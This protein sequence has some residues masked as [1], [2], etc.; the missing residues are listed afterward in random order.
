M[1]VKILK[2]FPYAKNVEGTEDALAPAG[3][4]IDLPDHMEPF[5]KGLAVGGFIAE[6]ADEGAQFA[7]QTTAP[8]ETGNAG[9]APENA[10]ANGQTE[11]ESVQQ[12]TETEEQRL[13]RLRSEYKELTGEEADGR[14][15]AD[16]L[17][18]LMADL[19]TKPE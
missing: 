16:K 18:G 6:P 19:R 1:R 8:P 13:E 7:R 11:T 4:T 15:G 12:P 17:E 10:S 9:S 14:F 3:K 5:L 2:T